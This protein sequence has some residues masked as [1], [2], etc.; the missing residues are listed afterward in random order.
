MSR[1][2]KPESVYELSST[3]R[4]RQSVRERQRGDV[5]EEGWVSITGAELA[6]VSCGRVC[7]GR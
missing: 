2:L 4:Q 6:L 1:A 3:R 5:T 7:I